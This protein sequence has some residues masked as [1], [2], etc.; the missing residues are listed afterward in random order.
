MKDQE[1]DHCKMQKVASNKSIGS[2][3][4]CTCNNDKVCFFFIEKYSVQPVDD[5]FIYQMNILLNKGEGGL[6][7][8]S[9]KSPSQFAFSDIVNEIS[10]VL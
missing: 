7:Q 6:Y 3:I 4:I 8:K 1:T 10:P 2:Y 5:W 9:E